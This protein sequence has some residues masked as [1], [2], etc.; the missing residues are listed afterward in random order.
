[1]LP[2]LEFK[3]LAVNGINNS[4][5]NNLGKSF[6]AQLALRPWQELSVLVGWLGGPEQDDTATIGC[7]VGESYD[8]SV[9]RCVEDPQSSEAM[10]ELVDRGGANRLEAWRHLLD[11][12]VNYQPMPTLRL[13]LNADY[14]TEGVRTSL[15]DDSIDESTWY[16]A[17]LGAELE[18]SEVW[19]LAGRGEYYADPDG[20]TTGIDDARLVS[21]TLTLGA[22]LSEYLLVRLE[23]RGDIALGPDDSEPFNKSVRE[24]S[25]SQFSATL[26]LVASSF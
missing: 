26:G 8:P 1:M 21:A 24:T 17:M 9:G 19:A 20:H 15:E 13:V 12:V 22:N 7:D 10:V 6:G 16:G 5:D 25:A 11:V 14:G 18:L 2:E 23:G 3:A 4:I